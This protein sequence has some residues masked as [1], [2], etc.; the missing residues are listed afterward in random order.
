MTTRISDVVKYLTLRRWLVS[1]SAGAAALVWGAVGISG[2]D[3]PLVKTEPLTAVIP[4]TQKEKPTFA[5]R[6]QDLLAA[7]YD[8]ANRPARG[9]TM[10]RGKAVQDGVRV[11]LPANMT[12][13][14][15][16]AMCRTTSGTRTPGPRA[17]CRCRIRITR[18]AG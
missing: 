6:Q 1:V 10:S 11:K 13:D 14:K 7:R 4:R 2:Q 15:L 3:D 5:K 16:A 8:L 18:R 12:W 9:V 17:S